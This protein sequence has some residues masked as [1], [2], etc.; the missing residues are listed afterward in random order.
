MNPLSIFTQAVSEIGDVMELAKSEVAVNYVPRDAQYAEVVTCVRAKHP[1]D[2]SVGFS[3][4]ET[5]SDLDF[6][7]ERY[8]G[9]LSHN[10][11]DLVMT[12]KDGGVVLTIPANDIVRHGTTEKLL[13]VTTA[14]TTY[15]FGQFVPIYGDAPVPF[16]ISA[17][18]VFGQ[19]A[20]LD[21]FVILGLISQETMSQSKKSAKVFLVVWAVALVGFTFL[22]ILVSM[23]NASPK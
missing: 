2:V 6:T 1:L 5:T 16:R 19:K 13:W 11:S 21:E 7:D 3:L 18:G 23:L 9:Y 15:A 12:T 22:F 17:N 8:V 10:G 14:Q 20:W 4:N